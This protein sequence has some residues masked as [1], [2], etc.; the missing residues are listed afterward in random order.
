MRWDR[1][2]AD[3]EAEAADLAA[4]DRD[5]EIAELTR[6]A[7]SE[8]RWLERVRGA[9]GSPATLVLSADTRVTGA[10]RYAG[11]DWVLV[12]AGSDDVL[13]PA[14]AVIGIEGVGSAAPPSADRVPLTWAAAWRSLSRDRASV[15]VRRTDGRQVRGT[16]GK[17]GADFVE[18][19]RDDDSRLGQM[20][21]V[22]FAAVQSV[23]VPREEQ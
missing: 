8:V 14:D 5:A 3:L 22:P 17:V 7:L 20:V 19:E 1:L 21:L 13:V 11:P 16:V 10:V 4:Q 2:F 23:H 18:L 15:L 9:T 6:A 12:E